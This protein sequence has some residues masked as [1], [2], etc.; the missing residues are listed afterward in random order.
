MM[1]TLLRLLW[2]WLMMMNQWLIFCD[3]VCARPK[4]THVIHLMRMTRYQSLKFYL[5]ISAAQTQ[6]L[7]QL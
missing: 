1:M 7:A 6:R 4:V 5:K 2:T 3:T